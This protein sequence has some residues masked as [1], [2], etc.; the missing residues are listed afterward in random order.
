MNLQSIISK[1]L[2]VIITVLTCIV[3]PPTAEV[4]IWSL[5]LYNILI[6]SLD[7]NNTNIVNHAIAAYIFGFSILIVYSLTPPQKVIVIA[8]GTIPYG[9]YEKTPTPF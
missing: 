5:F 9:Y 3:I 7:F 4:Y 1:I 8:L 2:M 6:L